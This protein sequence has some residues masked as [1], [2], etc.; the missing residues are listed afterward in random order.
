MLNDE[1]KKN[2]NKKKTQLIRLT[3]QTHD[4]SYEI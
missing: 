3:F 4:R 1:T 2:M